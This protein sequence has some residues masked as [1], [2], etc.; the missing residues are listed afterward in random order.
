M[1]AD[2]AQ[3]QTTRGRN[4]DRDRVAGGQDYEVDYEAKKTDSSREEV[5]DAVKSAG[6][7]RDAVEKKLSK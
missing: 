2:R 5:R 4:Q 7:S 1:E 3:E 6:S